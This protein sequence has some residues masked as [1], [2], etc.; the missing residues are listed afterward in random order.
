LEENRSLTE[1]L[2]ILEAQ[3]S[4]YQVLVDITKAKR[5]AMVAVDMPVLEEVLVQEEGAVARL[6]Q[7][8]SHR[9]DTVDSLKARWGLEQ[10]DDLDVRAILAR[11]PEG[12]ITRRLETVRDAL[13]QLAERCTQL[14]QLNQQLVD[15]SLTHIHTFLSLLVGEPRS[16][17]YSRQGTSKEVKG[18]LM[19]DRQA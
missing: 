15:Q 19:L 8:E 14:N 5:D 17:T 10:D 18:R 12:D 13:R 6:N 16:E 1:L 3:Q 2:E 4:T 9:T 7:L 11:L